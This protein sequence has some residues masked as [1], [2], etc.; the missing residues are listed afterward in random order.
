MTNIFLILFTILILIILQKIL[1]NIYYV[2]KFVG[3]ASDDDDN[4][5]YDNK[6][7][8][9]RALKRKNKNINVKYNCRT[10]IVE[11]DSDSD[12]LNLCAENGNSKSECINGFC[13]YVYNERE[14]KTFCQNGGAPISYFY[15]GQ[16][17]YEG[18]IC[19]PTF[20]GRFCEI[21]N[22]MI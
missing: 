21:P 19:P 11:C 3:L 10:T 1:R 15:R 9:Q 17:K 5:I 18:C 14:N 13:A 7:L 2:E 22:K 20:I 12:C 4:V 16:F 6:P 8:N